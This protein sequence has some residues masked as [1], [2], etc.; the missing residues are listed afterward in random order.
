MEKPMERQKRKNMGGSEDERNIDQRIDKSQ[1]II[2]SENPANEGLS[3][4]ERKIDKEHKKPV[5]TEA[6]N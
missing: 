5:I 3:E 4:E 1:E 6:A 2:R